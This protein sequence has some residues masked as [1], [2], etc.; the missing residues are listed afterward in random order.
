MVAVLVLGVVFWLPTIS[1]SRP[2]PKENMEKE[3]MEKENM[4]K[5]NMEKENMEKENMEKE[6]MEKENME[7]TLVSGKNARV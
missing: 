2:T 3:N 6:N 5:E 7:T 4:E 1:L